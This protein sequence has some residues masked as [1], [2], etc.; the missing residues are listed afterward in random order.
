MN[1]DI[2]HQI[3]VVV[4]VDVDAVDDYQDHHHK[5]ILSTLCIVVVVAVVAVVPTKQMEG[6]SQRMQKNIVYQ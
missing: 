6:R 4:D 5:N 2:H 1:H 3:V